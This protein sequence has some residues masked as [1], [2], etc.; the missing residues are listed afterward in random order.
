MVGQTESG[1]DA[2]EYRQFLD[3]AGCPVEDLVDAGLCDLGC[4]RDAY[5]AET[6]VF[7]GHPE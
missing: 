3:G 4:C 2:L 5:L 6:A 7:S 1:G